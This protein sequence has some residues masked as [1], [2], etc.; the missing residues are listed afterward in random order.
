MIEEREE[1]HSQ[2]ASDTPADAQLASDTPADAQLASEIP[3]DAQLASEIPTNALL[4]S[5][6]CVLTDTVNVC[7][8]SWSPPDAQSSF[9]S[10]I[11]SMVGLY[12]MGFAHCLGRL[13]HVDYGNQS[14]DATHMRQCVSWSRTGGTRQLAV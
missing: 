8:H 14:W 2:L 9:G 7:I 5:D 10:E 11:E 1:Q 13:E 4:A 3:A 6:V 12:R